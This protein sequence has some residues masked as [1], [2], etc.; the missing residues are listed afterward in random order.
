MQHYAIF[1]QDYTFEIKYKNS[2]LH[3]NADCLSRL[4][5]PVTSTA[6]Y[7]VVDIYEVTVLQDM[8]ISISKLTQSTKEDTQLKEILTALRD[9]KEVPAKLRFNINQAAFSIQEGILLC[10]GK[11][12]IPNSLRNRFLQDLHKS[13]FGVAKMKS[14]AR[15]LYWWPGLDKFLL[16][17]WQEIAIFV[18]RTVMTRQK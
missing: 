5:I 10:N 17:K 12:V 16:K 3:S 6:K 2:K 11:V 13:H 8:P 15:T 14:L 18:T 1:L 9:K 4:P 7:D